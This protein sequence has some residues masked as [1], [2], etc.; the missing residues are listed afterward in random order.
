MRCYSLEVATVDLGH[1]DLEEGNPVSDVAYVLLGAFVGGFLT[2]F[3]TL[4]TLFNQSVVTE[5]KEWRD[6]VRK[7]TLEVVQAVENG[8]SRDL[9]ALR[10]RLAIRLNPKDSDDNAILNCAILQGGETCECA[11]D[12]FVSRVSILLKHDWERSKL[13]TSFLEKHFVQ[14]HRPSFCEVK[15]SPE[16]AKFRKLRFVAPVIV[17]LLVAVIVPLIAEPHLSPLVESWQSG[18]NFIWSMTSAE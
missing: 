9:I 4:R 16:T 6:E 7:I 8:A 2:Y 10:Y 14:P 18:L 1:F 3:T 15:G 13:E 5:R 11:V 12:E 17:I